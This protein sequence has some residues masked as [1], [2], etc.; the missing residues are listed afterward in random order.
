MYHPSIHEIPRPRNRYSEH[1]SDP[2]TIEIDCLNDPPIQV[3]SLDKI[4][5]KNFKGKVIECKKKGLTKTAIVNLALNP[6][7]L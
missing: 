3:L 5:H 7:K 6:I 4:L 2:F 1:N